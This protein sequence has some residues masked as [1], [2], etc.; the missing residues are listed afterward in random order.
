MIP[1]FLKL[2]V[3]FSHLSV[4]LF[5][6]ILFSYFQLI[7]KQVYFVCQLYHCDVIILKFVQNLR[8]TLLNFTRQLL[9]LLLKQNCDFFT[10]LYNL[11]KFFNFVPCS[12]LLILKPSLHILH[13]LFHLFKLNL[14]NISKWRE[15][16]F[17]HSK[18]TISCLQHLRKFCRKFYLHRCNL[19][20]NIFCSYFKMVFNFMDL[21]LKLINDCN[22]PRELM[23]CKL[24]L[25]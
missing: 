9:D 16:V 8:L 7:W 4:V 10:I 21:S 24:D 5:H 12:K 23:Y 18:L 22:A 20:L 11:I 14:L 3:K 2:V 13:F 25:I 17:K 1:H 6:S 15:K 19:A